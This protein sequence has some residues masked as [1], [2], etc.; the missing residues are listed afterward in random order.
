[1]IHAEIK[2]NEKRLDNPVSGNKCLDVRIAGNPITVL[3][4]LHRLI[5]IIFECMFKNNA[6]RLLDRIPDAVRD[7]RD[8]SNYIRVDPEFL[9]LL[10]NFGGEEK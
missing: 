7:A 10:K 3:N 9:E 1:M 8:H 4:E 2:D 6:D 5:W